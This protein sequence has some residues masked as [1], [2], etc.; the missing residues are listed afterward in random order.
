METE[1]WFPVPIWRDNLGLNDQQIEFATSSCLALS[2]QSQ[3]RTLS[4]YGGWQSEE[5]TSLDI[6]NL[7]LSFIQ[8]TVQNMAQKCMEALG[9]DRL[10]SIGNAWVNINWR[11]HFNKPHTHPRADLVAVCYL[12][13][14]TS[15]IVFKRQQDVFH[16]FLENV[17]SNHLTDSS[18]ATVSYNPPK[19]TVIIFPSWLVHETQPHDGNNPRISVS[20]NFKST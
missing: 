6:E 4:N 17:S 14:A 12:T 10:V 1:F 5:L 18:F 3:G 19:N 16:Y 13:D 20:V 2:Q 9:S 7:G 11:G 15:P 8:T